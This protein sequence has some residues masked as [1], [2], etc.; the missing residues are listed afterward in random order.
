MY[1]AVIC[2]LVLI[3]Q[4]SGDTSDCKVTISGK[5][6]DLSPLKNE[7]SHPINFNL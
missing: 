7:L 4:C 2:L 5:S 1:A 6:Y 3:S